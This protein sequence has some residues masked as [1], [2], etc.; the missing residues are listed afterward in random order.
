[1]VYINN[2]SDKIVILKS[3]NHQIT[4]IE[5][6]NQTDKTK[7]VFDLS[8][9]DVEYNKHTISINLENIIESITVAGQY[10]YFLYNGEDKVQSGILQFS[11]FNLER[12]S[13]NVEQNI[14][15]YNV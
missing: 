8:E 15:Q 5:L 9:D 2:E 13:Y 1:M 4:K 11:D 10:D 6:V 14:I 12:N 3:Q 7:L